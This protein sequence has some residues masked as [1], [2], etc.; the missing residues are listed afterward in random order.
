MGFRIKNLSE[1]GVSAVRNRF[2]RRVAEGAEEAGLYR[3]SSGPADWSDQNL[4]EMVMGGA[5]PG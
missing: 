4:L 2:Y 3:I 1:L 5:V